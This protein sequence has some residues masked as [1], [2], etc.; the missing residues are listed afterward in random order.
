MLFI[1]I[2]KCFTV[3]G[4]SSFSGTCVYCNSNHFIGYD[5]PEEYP[6]FFGSAPNTNGK[7][8]SSSTVYVDVSLLK[9]LLFYLT[10]LFK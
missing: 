2:Y 7:S 6:L 1:Y 3:C 10:I 9:L 4:C 8:C 5:N